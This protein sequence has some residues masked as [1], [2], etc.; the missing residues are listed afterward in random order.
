MMRGLRGVGVGGAM[1]LR[2]PEGED[3]RGER[4]SFFFFGAGECRG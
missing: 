4:R 2:E 3:G 1:M